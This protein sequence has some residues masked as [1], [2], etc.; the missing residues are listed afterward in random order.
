MSGDKFEY[1]TNNALTWQER[2]KKK[3]REE[4]D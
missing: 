1:K 4:E 3:K 2:K